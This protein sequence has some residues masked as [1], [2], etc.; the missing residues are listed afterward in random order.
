MSAERR[1]FGTDGIRGEVGIHPITADFVLKLGWAAG[2]VLTRTARGDSRRARDLVVI[3]KDT[4]IS[5]Y[6]FESVLEAGLT[7]AGVD[8][9]LLG[10]MPTPAISYLTRTLHARAGIVISASHNAYMD[11]GIKFFDA[12]GSKLPDEVELAIEQELDV[13]MR[14]ASSSEL[15]KAE[16]VREGAGRYIEFC[17]STTPFGFDL[18][19]LRVVVDCAHGATYHIAPSVL[20]ELGAEVIPV[21]V[22]PNGLNINAGVGAL[23]PEHLRKAVLE[24]RADLGIAYDGDGD[25][26]MMVDHL[27]EIVDGDEMLFV[28]AESRR[29]EKRMHGP[30]VGT[31]M[32]NLGLEEALAERGVGL[33][34]TQVGDRHVMEGM[35]QNGSILGG[36][37]SGHILCLDC[38][39]SGDGIVSGLQALLACRTLDKTL[40]ELKSGMT[41]HPQALVNVKMKERVDVTTVP[42]VRDAVEAVES[43]LNGTGRVLLRLSGTE[44]LVRVMVEGRDHAAV[45][46][47]ARQIAEQVRTALG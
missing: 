44:P 27:G 10:P 22:E 25:R 28:I 42:A 20:D 31:V 15:G 40:H 4:R 13:E 5:G 16:R 47:Y 6:M 1:Y 12:D 3:G 41:K 45:N 7:A 11:N 36:E 38:S 30:V 19:G 18:K 33:V 29:H 23:S 24:Y 39:P 34:R 32:T 46:G 2:R 37:T 17:K 8:V 9:M 26:V 35:R 14:T 21:G 43:E